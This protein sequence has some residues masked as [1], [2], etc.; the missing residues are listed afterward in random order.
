MQEEQSESEKSKPAGQ[1]S[2]PITEKLLSWKASIG[3]A[4]CGMVRSWRTGLRT[5]FADEEEGDYN[6]M[7][8][9]IGILSIILFFALTMVGYVSVKEG[10]ME[11]K[12]VI[13]EP[14][15]QCLDCHTKKGLTAGAIRDWKMSQHAAK[16]IGCNECHI[17]TKD[18][19]ERIQ[20]MGTVC[21]DANVRL[22]VSSS[23]CKQCHETKVTE[24][25]KGKHAKAW[26]A[27]EAMPS[28][29]D[30]PEA[31]MAGEKGCGGCHKIGRDE[32]QCDSCHT[33]HLFSAEEARKPEACGTCHMGFDHP[34]WEMYITSKHG[35]IY[36]SEKHDYDFS[37]QIKEW[38]KEPYEPSTKTPRA[39]VCVTC[40][41]PDGSHDV[42]TAW[43]F[44]ALRLPEEDAEWMG[45]RATILQGLGVLDAEGNPTERLG[46]VK[47]AD[48][49]RLTKEDWEAERKKMV[50]VCAQCHGETWSKGELE[51][52]DGLIKEA[53]KL[54]AEAVTIVQALYDD[55]ILPRPTDYP[56]SV[57]LLRFYE[58]QSGIEQTLYVMFLEHRM[59]TFQGGFHSNPDYLH[60][61][62]WAEMKRDLVEIREEAAK[63][64]AEHDKK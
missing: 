8:Y 34:Q 12:P 47:A 36:Q 62:G 25:A 56:A 21:E 11:F 22:E 19:P 10:K 58:V 1:A 41:M 53:D 17:P 6:L 43:G 40:H 38:Y 32:G 50:D 7:K 64:R 49:A 44:L 37:K 28:T 4:L 35:M 60:W 39:P 55:G 24:F 33:R 52:I 23:N 63:L 27:M 29:K 5:I 9:F 59:R 14:G 31:I 46:A 57:D 26:L 45:Y 20:S 16:G 61:Y 13:T 15:K 3:A 54:M 42:L 2:D 48:M 51:K 18:A 30:Q